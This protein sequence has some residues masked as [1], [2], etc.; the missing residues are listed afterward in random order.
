MVLTGVALF[1]AKPLVYYHNIWFRLKLVFLAGAMI[2]IAV[3]HVRIQR[4]QPV[5]DDAPLPPVG[6]RASAAVSLM[7]WLLIIVM[8]RF[9]AYNWYECGKPLPD[10]LNAAQEC[11]ASEHGAV[12][13]SGLV[14]HIPPTSPGG[15]P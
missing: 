13:L 2:N 3:F 9:I 14:S 15:R 4:H 5:W 10:A 7:A 11:A 6:A 8:G 12:S 1:V